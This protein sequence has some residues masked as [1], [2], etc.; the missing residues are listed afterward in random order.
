MLRFSYRLRHYDH[1]H[2]YHSA[3]LSLS[4][5]G[6]IYSSP[7]FSYNE[8]PL[9]TFKKLTKAFSST[10]FNL[11]NTSSFSP[12]PTTLSHHLSHSTLLL[13]FFLSLSLSLASSIVPANPLLFSSRPLLSSELLLSQSNVCVY[14]I[15]SEALLITATGRYVA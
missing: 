1:N 10:D 15:N 12:M 8:A 11:F 14:L 2:H 6:K 7:L 5:C 9:H 4:F 3:E 13:S